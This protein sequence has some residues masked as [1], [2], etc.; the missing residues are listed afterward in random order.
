[1]H[2]DSI[3]RLHAE[4]RENKT[5]KVMFGSIEFLRNQFLKID[6]PSN[7]SVLF[8]FLETRNSVS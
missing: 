2:L 8:Q 5:T 6:G 1:M 7:G 3:E 4:E